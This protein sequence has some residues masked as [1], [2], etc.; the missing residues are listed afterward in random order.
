MNDFKGSP[1]SVLHVYSIKLLSRSLL[2]YNKKSFKD[3]DAE[4][5]EKFLLE[6]PTPIIDVLVNVY[7]ELNEKLQACIKGSE[8]EETF[9]ETPLTS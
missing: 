1:A 3:S 7:N 9:F 6:L 4:D 5:I 8:I 2:N